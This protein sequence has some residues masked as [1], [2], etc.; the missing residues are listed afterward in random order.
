[1]AITPAHATGH[2]VPPTPL[3]PG[4]FCVVELVPNLLC[5]KS[6]LSFDMQEDCSQYNI[7]KCFCI[8]YFL[9]ISLGFINEIEINAFSEINDVN[10]KGFLLQMPLQKQLQ[11][12]FRG[13]EVFCLVFILSIYVTHQI[14]NTFQIK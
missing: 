8:L 6:A 1:M 13:R 2:N 9:P 14:C 5:Q 12:Q 4:T 10:Q 11:R 3:T 7:I